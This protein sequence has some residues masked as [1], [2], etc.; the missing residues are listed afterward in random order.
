MNGDY[1]LQNRCEIRRR[2]DA[3]FRDKGNG[4]RVHYHIFPEYEVHANELAPHSTQEW[5]HHKRIVEALYIISGSVEARWLDDNGSKSSAILSSGDMIDVGGTVH[6]FQNP[7]GEPCHFVVF[8]L[9]PDGTDKHELI[10]NDRYA[11]VVET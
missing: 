10:K 5:H 11:D 4:T 8:R 7:T 9:V 1:S 6:T 3:I 2:S